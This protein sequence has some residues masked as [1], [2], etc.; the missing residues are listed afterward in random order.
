LRPQIRPEPIPRALRHEGRDCGRR[1]ACWRSECVEQFPGF[2]TIE[3]LA[4]GEVIAHCHR[5]RFYPRAFR[6]EVAA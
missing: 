1:E 3:I 5:T 2:R 6:P 4:D